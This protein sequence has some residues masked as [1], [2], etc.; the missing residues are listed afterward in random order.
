MAGV[1]W[2][3]R[4]GPAVARPGSTV[5]R[6]EEEA[7]PAISA[8]AATAA[9]STGSA[10]AVLQ[11]QRIQGNRFVQRMVALSRAG[12]MEG[13]DVPEETAQEIDRARSGGRSLDGATRESMESAFGADFGGVRVHTGA[14][15]DRLNGDLSARAFTTG[16]DIFFRQGEYEP[17]RSSGRELLAHELTHVVQQGGGGAVQGKLTVGPADHPAE[18]EADQ[19]AAAVI[20]RET[21]SD[22]DKDKEKA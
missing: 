5:A 19:A 7:M 18:R 3:Q 16:S 17:G 9:T 21:A 22:K 13:G 11:A 4:V 6:H 20:A 14:A 10:D 8:T 2:E 15:A 1:L 12:S